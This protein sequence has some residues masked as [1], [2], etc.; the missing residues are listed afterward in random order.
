M[1]IL[2][3]IIKGSHFAYTPKEIP[4]GSGNWKWFHGADYIVK[5]RA[6]ENP[7][8]TKLIGMY[9][10]EKFSGYGIEVVIGPELGAIILAH[11]VASQLTELESPSFQPGLAC[12][13]NIYAEKKDRNLDGSPMVIRRGFDKLVSGRKVLVV[14]DVLTSGGS[15]LRVVEAVKAIGGEV[16]GVGAICNRGDVL[17][18]AVG[19]VPIVAIIETR[20]ETY[21]E[22]NCPL[23]K[24]GVPINI[25]YGK[26]KEWLE[27]KRSQ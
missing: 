3:A 8:M 17:P 22:D 5:E 24:A 16:A 21:P 1:E 26:G 20:M 6:L 10:A 19:N 18:E 13:S 23:C 4:Q 25:E 7:L 15:V 9:L 14:E 2:G 11:E 12:I 27:K